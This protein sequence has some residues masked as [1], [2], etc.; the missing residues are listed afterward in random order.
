MIS[1]I[2]I[3]SVLILFFLIYLFMLH[4]RVGFTHFKE[5]KNTLFAHRGLFGNGVPENSLLAFKKAIDQGFGAELDIHLTK[6]GKLAVI[7]DHSLKRTAGADLNIEELT[8]SEAQKFGLEN[9]DEK[10]PDFLDVLSLF[11]NKKPLII[12]LK[13]TGSNVNELCSKTAEILKNYKGI[14]CIESFDPRVVR[15]FKKNCPQII[16]G[17][18]SENFLRNKKSNLNFFAKLS[19]TLLLTNFLT[20]PDFVAFRFNHRKT[21]SFRLATG[22]LKLQKVGWTIKTKEDIKTAQNENIIPIFEDR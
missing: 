6:D 19:M 14:Y 10:I 4:G 12:E 17:Q 15:W 21:L 8:L 16:R 1:V 11:E 20:S 2:I 7:H 18:L 13:S 22:L 9:T 3:N 5:F